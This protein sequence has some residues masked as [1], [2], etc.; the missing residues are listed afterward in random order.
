MQERA[1][2]WESEVRAWESERERGRAK[3][4]NA[5][6]RARDEVRSLE[7]RSESQQGSETRGEVLLVFLL[8]TVGIYI[9]SENLK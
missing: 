5:I 8:C 7:T 9:L 3:S 2:A 6:S 1:K 4:N